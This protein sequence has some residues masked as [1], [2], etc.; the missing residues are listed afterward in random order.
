MRLRELL[1]SME[2]HLLG[3]D[4]EVEVHS[5]A[6]DSREVGKGG[7]FVCLSGERV[8]GH[9]YIEQAAKK[10]AVAIII[11]KSHFLSQQQIKICKD[12]AVVGVADPRK[13]LAHLSAT[14]F[15]Y[16]ADDLI[17]I[18]ITGTKGKTTT[19]HMIK[20]TL[21]MDGYQVGMI[22]TLGAYIGDEKYPTKNTTPES[23]EIYHL[24]Y[25]MRESGCSH[26][27]MEVSSQAL[28]QHRT[29]GI[30]FDYGAFLN[31]SSD[32]IGTGEH[33]DFKEYFSCKKRLFEQSKQIVVNIDDPSWKQMTRGGAKVYTTS[34]ENNADYMGTNIHNTW[35]EGLLGVDFTLCGTL[36]DSLEGRLS[37]RIPGDF[38]V[39]NALIAIAITHQ[40]GASKEAIVKGLET[41]YV[42][43]RTQVI[44]SATH[45][46]T[47]LID[48]AHNALSMESLLKMLREYQPKR[49]ICL[50]GG[51]GNKPKQR[52]YD[53]GAMAGK[54]AD[55]TVL[56]MDNPRYEQVEDINLEII[57]GINEYNGKYIT[58]L[59]RKEAI[60]YLIDHCGK[61]D[62]VAL[63]G[64]GHEEYQEI[65][66]QKF[67]FS[68]EQIIEQY[69]E[70]K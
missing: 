68:E 58:I 34:R 30:I 27:V 50:F 33:K 63:I 53:M 60:H 1:V 52:R 11:E 40:L 20:R 45:F 54:Y 64:K 62:I 61:G 51:G 36:V 8:D 44:R 38:N 31:I 5:I 22:G 23:Y 12:I 16:P 59:D 18:G 7:L 35:N 46:L 70:E 13:T 32:H 24:F 42:K 47:I 19:T 55:L 25:K 10:G 26:V 65:R 56:S 2:Y 15:G 9:D 4:D 67:F 17:I 57:Q 37:L 28:K 29:D 39:E 49:L 3:G 6:Y 69:L 21:E 43:G 66:G 14:W 41:V 48:Y